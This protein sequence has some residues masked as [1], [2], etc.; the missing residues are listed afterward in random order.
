MFVVRFT[1]TRRCC[2]RP[3]SRCWWRGGG[4]RASTSS[5]MPNIAT[6]SGPTP[7][8]AARVN[9]RN[10][11]GVGAAGGASGGHRSAPARV[12]RRRSGMGTPSGPGVCA[13]S[14]CSAPPMGCKVPSSLLRHAS[15]PCAP[16]LRALSSSSCDVSC[17]GGGGTGGGGGDGDCCCCGCCCCCCCCG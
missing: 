9:G 12:T 16:P 13:L 8:A 11:G 7:R 10:C 17:N 14:R 6:M 3:V 1:V 5:L 4:R 2:G 15:S